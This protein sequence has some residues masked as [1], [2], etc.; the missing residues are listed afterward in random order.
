MQL[1][2]ATRRNDIHQASCAK[3]ILG[4]EAVGENSDLF[5]GRL[6]QSGKNG[7]APPAIHS[8]RAVHDEVGLA[9]T[10]AIRREQELVHE[11]VALIDGGAIRGIEQGK[12]R[13]AMSGSGNARDL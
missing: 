8:V 4:G 2:S 7:L 13:D 1:L 3:T 6:R 9:P 12:I 10:G 11:D 5:N